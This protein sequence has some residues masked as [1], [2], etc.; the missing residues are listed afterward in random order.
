VK[1]IVVSESIR[2]AARR[3]AAAARDARA[4][5]TAILP[6]VVFGMTRE[7][8]PSG[9]FSAAFEALT[10]DS[11]YR[12][13][14]ASVS[15]V[16]DALGLRDDSAVSDLPQVMAAAQTSVFIV[17]YA[18]LLGEDP[19]YVWQSYVAEMTHIECREN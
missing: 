6:V 15:S 14:Q 16:L 1:E 10:G 18:A 3:S 17:R 4:W 7:G 11:E 13:V 8:P 9:D 19:H 5:V 12:Q 2:Q